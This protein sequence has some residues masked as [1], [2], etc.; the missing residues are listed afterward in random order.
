M[1]LDPK[2][3]YAIRHLEL[4]PVEINRADYHML[5]RVPGIGVKSA[6]RIVKARRMAALDFPDLKKIGVVLKRA[7][8]FITCQ[9]KMMYP[10]KLSEDS[11]TGYLIDE[12]KQRE[13]KG[14]QLDYQQLSLFDLPSMPTDQPF[15]IAEKGGRL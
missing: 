13:L 2:C 7:V 12:R 1:L 5:L 14:G 10:V 8:Y 3:D 15:S 9:G 6:Q 11:I 4:F